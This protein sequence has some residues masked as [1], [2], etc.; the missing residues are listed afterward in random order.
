M[1]FHA[2]DHDLMGDCTFMSF[3]P[4]SQLGPCT[5]MGFVVARS[6]TSREK[7]GDR[8]RINRKRGSQKDSGTEGQTV[9]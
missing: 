8:G 6:T 5:S 3:H 4:T 7:K 2:L 1:L 9:I